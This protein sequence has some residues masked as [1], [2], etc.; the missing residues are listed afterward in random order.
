MNKGQGR[1]FH[2]QLIRHITLFKGYILCLGKRIRPL[3]IFCPSGDFSWESGTTLPCNNF[4][5]S[6]RRQ[7]ATFICI[8]YRK[9]V[10]N[11][12]SKAKKI[13]LMCC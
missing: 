2:F 8:K 13:L 1:S 12:L 3:I 9:R 6:F 11:E 10:R 5:P 7:S 4:K